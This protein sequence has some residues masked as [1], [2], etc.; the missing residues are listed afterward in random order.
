[1]R[2]NYL[3]PFDIH[4]SGSVDL[5]EVFDKIIG[6]ENVNDLFVVKLRQIL[7]QDLYDFFYGK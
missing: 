6:T 5:F 2:T 7:N 3:P 1:M 4:Q